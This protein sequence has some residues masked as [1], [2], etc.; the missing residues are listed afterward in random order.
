[1]DIDDYNVVTKFTCVECGKKN[2]PAQSL[3][4]IKLVKKRC[5]ECG[6]GL[7]SVEASRI[8][9]KLYQRKRRERLLAERL[10]KETTC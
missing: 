2:V 10:V 7:K 8:R 5:P 6:L 4:E 3:K 1:M 9:S